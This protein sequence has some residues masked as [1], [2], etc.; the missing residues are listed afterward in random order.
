MDLDD[1]SFE[2][3]VAQDLISQAEEEPPAI[4]EI[5]LAAAETKI[6]GA[7][8]TPD[9]DGR[10]VVVEMKS[11]DEVRVTTSGRI[12]AAT[13]V[14]IPA[15]AT[16]MIHLDAGTVAPAD[17]VPTA[18]AASARPVPSAPPREWFTDPHLSGPTPLTVTD[19]G[20]V[21]GHIALW[22]MCH[23]GH[24]TAGKCITPPH[25]SSGYQWFHTG[26][27]HTSDH[28]ELA[29]GHLTL[30][31]RHASLTASP[32]ATLAHYEDTGLVAADVRAGEDGYGLWVAGAARPGLSQEK[33][34]AL[35]AAPMSG[36]W[37]R[38][39]ASQELVAVLAVNVP[40]FPVPRPAGLVAGGQLQSLVA[41]GMVPPAKI[42]NPADPSAWLST[43][44]LRYLKRLAQR[45]ADADALVAS[46][47]VNK[48]HAFALRRRAH[49]RVAGGQ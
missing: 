38:I 19:D 18:L 10:V 22:G 4:M 45:E 28:I 3:R 13:L 14:A 41:S 47:A 39:G 48:I 29:V 49:A 34:R 16:A 6:Q 32:A 43:E 23:L 46:A 12:R 31:T 7:Q 44:D 30:D 37:R 2:V 11:D 36:D 40:G 1:V 8:A 24:A 27:I 21:Y 20:R 33:L 5:P 17:E 9:A 25:S 35:R 26:A 15:F 42:I